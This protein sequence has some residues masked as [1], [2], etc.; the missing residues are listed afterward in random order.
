WGNLQHVDTLRQAGRPHV[1]E[2]GGGA[3]PFEP[4]GPDEELQYRELHHVFEAK[5]AHAS[6]ALT[7]HSGLHIACIHIVLHLFGWDPDDR[8]DLTGFELE[9]CHTLTSKL[10]LFISFN[11][12]VARNVPQHG[13]VLME[14]THP[15]LRCIPS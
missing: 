13:D 10:K 2:H 1:G 15:S 9:G 12:T 11:Y 8:C 7:G 14:W 5:Q 6:T 3:L 4:V